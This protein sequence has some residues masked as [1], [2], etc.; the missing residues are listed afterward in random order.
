MR[1]VVCREFKGIEGL[2][3]E[4]LPAPALRP[5]TVRVRVAA[6]GVN[7]A[8]TLIVQG[9]Y[10]VKPAF[11]FSPGIEAAGTV[12][13]TAPDVTTPQVGT[14][15]IAQV[16]YG[17]FAE[18]LVVPAGR[19]VAMPAGMEFAVGAGFPVVYGTSYG[20]LLW[21]GQLKAGETLLVLGAAGGVGLTAVEIGK[22]AG[23][24]VIA[25]ARGAEK[26]A[27]ARAHGADHV[28]DYAKEDLRTRVKELTQGKG[29]DV[30]Y[31]PVG[32]DLFDQAFRA[33]NWEGRM[34]I[35]GFAGGRIQQIPA[36][37]IMVKSIACVG[38]YWGQYVDRAP[39]RTGA[40][41]AHLFDWW[42]QGKLK[43][44]ISNRLPLV[45]AREAL[46]LLVSRQATGKVVLT[47][48]EAG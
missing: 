25:A 37:H 30:V 5:G 38:F 11:P 43:P 39:E 16:S 36:N 4:D 21:R 20:G 10:Q 28:I 17:A 23:A 34:V 22:A 42:S 45:Q 29:A 2:T 24:T 19:A 40:A 18:E 47:L 46:G 12:I 15:V 3:V 27:I 33:I 14:R 32:G 41:L 48:D 8:D 1:A 35:I 44:F 26:L 6:A 9:R 31:D 13:E 7:F